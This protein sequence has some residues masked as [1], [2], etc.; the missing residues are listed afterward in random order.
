MHCWANKEEVVEQLK[1]MSSFGC[2][3]HDTVEF[4]ILRGGNKAKKQN[5]NPALKEKTL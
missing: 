4:R 2:S 3:D 1:I 5:H